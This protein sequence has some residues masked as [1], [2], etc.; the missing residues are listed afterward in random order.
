M[1]QDKSFNILDETNELILGHI[2]ENVFL[3]NKRTNENLNL[4]DIFGDPSCGLISNKNDWCVVG[5][6]NILVWTKEKIVRINDDPLNWIYG[7]RQTN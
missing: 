6:S 5:G 7:I 1:T 3:I 2:F 4:G